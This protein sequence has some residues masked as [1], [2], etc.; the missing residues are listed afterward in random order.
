MTDSSTGGPLLP[1]AAPAPV[2]L[3]GTALNEFLAPI[4]SALTTLDPTLV[5]PAFQGEPPDVPD[6]GTAWMAFR[7]TERPIDTYPAF[8]QHS[9]GYT[10]MQ[11]HEELRIL[12]SF[13][14]LGTSGLADFYAALLRDN[15]MIPQNAE[16]FA[17][18]GM[19]L[20]L[21]GDKTAVPLLVKMRWQYKC[22]LPF[23]L[24]RPVVRWYNVLNVAR[25]SASISTDSGFTDN[26]TV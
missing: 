26:I 10:E 4:L 18:Q 2:P 16:Y 3:D 5:R 19:G 21:V 17:Q 14:D 13:Y 7:C 11:R 9:E 12:C 22:D 1:Q 23:V 25:G 15:L 20:K 6:A 24:R 8:V